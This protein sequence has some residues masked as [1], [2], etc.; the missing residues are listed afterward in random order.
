MK[1]LYSTESTRT[2]TGKVFLTLNTAMHSKCDKGSNTLDSFITQIKQLP[3]RSKK[4]ANFPEV[5]LTYYN[6]FLDRRLF[7]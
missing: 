1:K 3:V 7:L 2:R 6:C 4:V 5:N